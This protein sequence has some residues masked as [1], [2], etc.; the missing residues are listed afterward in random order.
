LLIITINIVDKN[1]F[2][3]NRICTSHSD[4]A[5]SRWPVSCELLRRTS[6]IFW[7]I[8]APVRILCIIN[9]SLGCPDDQVITSFKVLLR[10]S[11]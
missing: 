5:K 3:F 2:Y 1:L 4:V 9:T 10:S 7:F 6:F 11:P 8:A